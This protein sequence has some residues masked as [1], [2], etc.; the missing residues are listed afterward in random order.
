MGHVILLLKRS[1]P[2]IPCTA[3]SSRPR[4]P[5]SGAADRASNICPFCRAWSGKRQWL[6]LMTISSKILKWV[7]AC[8]IMF[9]SLFL[10]QFKLTL[11]VLFLWFFGQ[12][13][14]LDFWADFVF[15]LLGQLCCIFLQAPFIS[16]NSSSC[17]IKKFNKRLILKFYD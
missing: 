12:I 10:F 8:K 11:Q 4:G 3:S 7:I 16:N 13:C 14:I 2:A 15:G 9:K 17:W 6:V 1:Y 5:P